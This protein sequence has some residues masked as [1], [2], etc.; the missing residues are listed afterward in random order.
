MMKS[1]SPKFSSPSSSVYRIRML[2]W[3]TSYRIKM[4]VIQ[5][6]VKVTGA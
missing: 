1:G 3:T 4:K 6:K 2:F 5:L